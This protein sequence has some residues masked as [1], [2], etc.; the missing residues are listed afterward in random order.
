MQYNSLDLGKFIASITIVA[1]HIPPFGRDD[2]LLSKGVNFA[3]S[4]AVPYF[5]AV[6]AFL[7]SKT[8]KTKRISCYSNALALSL[9]LQ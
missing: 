6:S 5:I 2:S 1:L 9:S 4:P 8:G 3:T 7:F